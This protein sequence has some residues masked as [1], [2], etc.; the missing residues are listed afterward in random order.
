LPKKSDYKIVSYYNIRNPSVE[1]FQILYG[2]N[3]YSTYS[4]RLEAEN[5][6]K[7]LMADPWFFDRGYTKKDRCEK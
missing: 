4:T 6:V 1:K 7:K 3:P 2:G 5:I